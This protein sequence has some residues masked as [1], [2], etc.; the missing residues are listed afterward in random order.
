MLHVYN[1]YFLRIFPLWKEETNAKNGINSVFSFYKFFPFMQ[2]TCGEKVVICFRVWRQ[3]YVDCIVVNRVCCRRMFL[4]TFCFPCLCWEF[5]MQKSTFTHKNSQ[6]F[7]FIRSDAFA[8]V[9]YLCHIMKKK[10]KLDLSLFLCMR[11]VY[12]FKQHLFTRI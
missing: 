8:I 4:L 1:F 3:F 11:N 6:F 7:R 10:F 12:D 9:K 2:Y 5:A